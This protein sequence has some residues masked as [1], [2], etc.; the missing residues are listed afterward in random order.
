MQ[1]IRTLASDEFDGR[2][3]GTK[4]EELTVKYLTEQFRSRGLWHVTDHGGA[5]RAV[6]H[7]GTWV[8]AGATPV[9]ELGRPPRLDS[10]P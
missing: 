9:A 8:H 1:H 3:P 7:V 2:L 10:T 4:G 6:R 5:H